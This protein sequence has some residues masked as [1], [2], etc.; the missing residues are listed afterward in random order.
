MVGQ[1]PLASGAKP[2]GHVVVS[3]CFFVVD[4]S[5]GG[6]GTAF[7]GG[8]EEG[9]SAFPNCGLPVGPRALAV[10]RKDTSSVQI[11]NEQDLYRALTDR[12]M[13]DMVLRQG[14]EYV[15]PDKETFDDT[16]KF[17]KLRKGDRSKIV[18]YF[19]TLKDRI[20]LEELR[21]Y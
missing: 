21:F 9:G 8:D 4:G 10:A 12:E 20:K 14:L 17:E 6:G 11:K 15:L 5:V 18:D 13:L 16:S 1:L 2:L 3:V 19:M 7:E